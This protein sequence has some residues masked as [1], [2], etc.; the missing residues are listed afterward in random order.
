MAISASRVDAPR[1][2]SAGFGSPFKAAKRTAAAKNGSASDA[3]GS[4]TNGRS[5]VYMLT[6][7]RGWGLSNGNR[8]AS[9]SSLAPQERHPR[10]QAHYKSRADENDT[11]TA[12]FDLPPVRNDDAVAAPDD[13]ED[14]RRAEDGRKGNPDSFHRAAV[15]AR[16]KC[17]PP[18]CRWRRVAANR[19]AFNFAD[20]A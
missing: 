13:E 6:T 18:L 15:T 12:A 10:N 2:T 14:R 3:D 8:R 7:P 11:V 9:A 4:G 16:R 1:R 5:G 19:S 20:A 17:F